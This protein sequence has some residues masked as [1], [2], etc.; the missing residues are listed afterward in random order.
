VVLFA[1]NSYGCFERLLQYLVNLSL[2]Q[3]SGLKLAQKMLKRKVLQDNPIQSVLNLLKGAKSKK[4]NFFENPP[5]H[6]QGPS[7]VRHKTS[8]NQLGQGIGLSQVESQC[9]PSK[10]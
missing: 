4:S 5:F 6:I 9:P 7:P 8:R 1:E 2:E 10:F 3:Y